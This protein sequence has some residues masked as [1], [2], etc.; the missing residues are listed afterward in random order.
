M[1][2]CRACDVTCSLSSMPT[3]AAKI[4][5]HILIAF[6]AEVLRW[7]EVFST[8]L[9]FL[10]NFVFSAS[11]RLNMYYFKLVSRIWTCSALVVLIILSCRALVVLVG[12]GFH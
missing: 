9:Y 3:T 7:L 2:V 6:F 4:F 12:F 8:A 5:A 1:K 11:S 10:N